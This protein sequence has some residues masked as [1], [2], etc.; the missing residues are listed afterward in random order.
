MTAGDQGHRRSAV[1]DKTGGCLRD[2]EF[3]LDTAS[4]GRNSEAHS[5]SACG[6]ARAAN[7]VAVS[8]GL[9]PPLRFDFTAVRQSVAVHR[10]RPSSRRDIFRWRRTGE[11]TNAAN[12]PDAPRDHA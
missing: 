4:V 5:A 2:D 12:P 3:V 10:C 6:S 1:L 7:G 9:L 8:L 11:M